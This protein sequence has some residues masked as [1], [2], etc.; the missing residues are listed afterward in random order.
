VELAS[1]FSVQSF[2]TQRNTIALETVRYRRGLGNGSELI[3]SLTLL[4]AMAPS[5][6]REVVWEIGIRHQ[7]GG[8][9][10]SRAQPRG[11]ISGTVRLEDSSG[12]HPLEGAEITLDGGRRTTSD[13]EGHY[14][15]AGLTARFHTVQI[16]FRSAR[17]FWYSTPSKVSTRADS[18]VDFGVVYA[19]AQLIGYV[20]DDSHM[21]LP[22]IGLSVRGLQYD[23]T[24]ATDEQGHFVTPLT[25][26]G[27]YV[28]GINAETVPDGY[29]VEELSPVSVSV[30]EGQSQN[31]SFTVSAIRALMGSVQ[32][33]DVAREQYVPAAGVRIG[34]PELHKQ[35][36]SGVDGHYLFRDMPSGIFTVVVN[37]E[38]YGHVELGAAPQLLRFDIRLHSAAI[39]A[40]Q[41]Q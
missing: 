10:F 30:D 14:R 3:S 16:Q 2:L 40:A 18:I 17:P 21:P 9:P 7:L 28:I 27:K 32:T 34:I 38:E 41:R 8:N 31:V 4:D 12:T 24:I 6:R 13:A 15:F 39:A 26:A 35:T 23:R 37:G 5:A 33:Y 11:D 29:A 22:G 20:L 25:A 19:S 1:N 36:T